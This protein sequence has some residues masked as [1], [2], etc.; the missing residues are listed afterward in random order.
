MLGSGLTDPSIRFF[1]V[2]LR[3]IYDDRTLFTLFTWSWLNHEFC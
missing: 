2:D 3:D 1:I